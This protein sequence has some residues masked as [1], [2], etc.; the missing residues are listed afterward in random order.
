MLGWEDPD[1]FH[2]LDCRWEAFHKVWSVILL[3][4]C[5][6][7]MQ[8]SLQY[9]AAYIKQGREDLQQTFLKYHYCAPY[10]EARLLHFNGCG[11]KLEHC[12]V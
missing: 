10:L 6:D 4:Y 7:N 2:I 9:L 1:L 12:K 8:L 3:Q 5:R 11:P